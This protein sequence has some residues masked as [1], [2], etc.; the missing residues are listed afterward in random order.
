MPWI[1]SYPLFL[2]ARTGH[3]PP[4][5]P[6]WFLFAPKLYIRTVTNPIHF[7]PE[8]GVRICLETSTEFSISTLRK[9]QR[10]ESTSTMNHCESLNSMMKRMIYVNFFSEGYGGD[11]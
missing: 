9:Y 11:T 1:S 4:L 3:Q 5:L 8:G 6:P 7:N 2:L 10:A